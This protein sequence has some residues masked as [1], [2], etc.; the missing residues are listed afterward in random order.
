MEIAWCKLWEP[1]NGGPIQPFLDKA[2]GIMVYP[3]D[4]PPNTTS[5][6]LGAVLSSQNVCLQQ[7]YVA[8]ADGVLASI[9]PVLAAY[10]RLYSLQ[11]DIE[12]EAQCCSVLNIIASQ[13]RLE[14]L[15]LTNW[16]W[17]VVCNGVLLVSLSALFQHSHFHSLCLSG[18]TLSQQAV[19]ELVAA[20]FESTTVPTL[21]E[22]SNIT[23]QPS[24]DSG[25]RVVRISREHTETFGPTKELRLHTFSTPL[26]PVSFWEWFESMPYIRLGAFNAVCPCHQDDMEGHFQHHPNFKVDRASHDAY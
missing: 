25:H 23:I 1:D 12:H 15:R 16:D 9:E 24:T 26:I 13:R 22:L 5:T 20:F 11:L 7:L 21:L 2:T 17:N 10:G 8:S 3:R 4:E 14:F 19:E 18:F 6:I